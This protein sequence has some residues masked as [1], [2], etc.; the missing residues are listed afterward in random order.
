MKANILHVVLVTLL[1][2]SGLA[3]AIAQAPAG[4]V[5]IELARGN[6]GGVL[7]HGVVP[8]S[9]AAGTSLVAGD[10]VMSIDGAAARTTTDLRTA[11]GATPIGK[12]IELEVRAA[13]GT[14]RKVVVAPAA[15][16]SDAQLA[17][18]RLVD[19]PA[20]DFLLNVVGAGGARGGP[21]QL[22][23]ARFR[24]H[25]LVIDFWATW[26]GPCVRALPELGELSKRY[27]PRGVSVVG[28]STEAPNVLREA[29]DR[30]GITHP[31]LVD[32]QESVFRS[33]SVMALPT[34]VLVDRE[35]VVR[36][37]EVGGNIDAIE[38]KL[39][40]LLADERRR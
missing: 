25:P 16:P 5:G 37:V 26:C 17:R 6:H 7:I 36:A 10:E 39:R 15:R 34:L 12:R 21:P 13:D 2:L 31:I 28:V 19:K 30:L 33:Y 32:K 35:G 24:G 9:P 4:W 40:E 14:L 3:D 11:I 38:A 8:D 18:Q 29:I 22:G 23:T 27:A 1:I 20:P